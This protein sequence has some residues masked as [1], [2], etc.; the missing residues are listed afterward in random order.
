MSYYN[1]NHYSDSY[2]VETIREG[3]VSIAKKL[4]RIEEKN[5]DYLSD[6]RWIEL[7]NKQDHFYDLLRRE[8]CLLNQQN[9]KNTPTKL[10][11]SSETKQTQDLL[12]L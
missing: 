2:Y 5:P 4:A 7:R 8:E 6:K 11:E 10:K 1:Y 12:Q 3:L 9:K